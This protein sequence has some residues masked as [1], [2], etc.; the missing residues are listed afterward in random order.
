MR[1]AELL[2]C[3]SH[4]WDFDVRTGQSWFDPQRLRVRRYEVSVTPGAALVEEEEGAPAP[5]MQKGP[6]VAETYPVSVEQQYI[7]IELDA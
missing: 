5:G 4:V 6:Y 3:T 7:V 1:P 2:R